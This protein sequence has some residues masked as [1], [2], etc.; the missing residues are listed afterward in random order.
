MSRSIAPKLALPLL[1]AVGLLLI[2]P[3]PA[4]ADNC[5]TRLDCWVTAAGGGSAALGAAI[6][7]VV[8]FGGGSGGGRR[9]NDRSPEPPVDDPR[10]ASSSHDDYRDSLQAA[11]DLRRG[12]RERN[13]E[14]Y[15][16]EPPW[17]DWDDKAYRDWEHRRW[18]DREWES[19]GDHRFVDYAERDGQI[20]VVYYEG[21]TE[22][23]RGPAS[24]NLQKN[25]RNQ[26][27][28]GPKAE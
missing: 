24:P 20:D 19:E 8:F 13:R 5:S 17:G 2:V 26:R 15:D 18:A 27:S 22:T 28:G 3:S 21:P 23:Y 6:I 25:W 11:E 12:Q 14:L 10:D 1:I 7:T 16:P 4:L 9:A